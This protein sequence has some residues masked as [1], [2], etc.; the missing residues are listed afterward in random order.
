MVLNRRPSSF[1][2]RF[3][4]DRNALPAEATVSAQPVTEA[5]LAPLQPIMQTYP[6]RMGAVG[7]ARVRNLRVT[8]KAQMRSSA[9]APWMPAMAAQYEFFERPARLFHMNAGRAGL[10]FD[11]FHRY[12]D[13]AATFLV[14][15]AGLLPEV[16]KYGTAITNDETVTLIG[17]TAVSRSRQSPTT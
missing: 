11:I 17:L 13:G 9:T 15:F 16:D 3:K 10:P 1:G 5:D 14:R 7:R 2:S 8:F 6:R 4:H 12:V